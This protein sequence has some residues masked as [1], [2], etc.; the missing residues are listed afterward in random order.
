[1]KKT[2]FVAQMI[3]CKRSIAY[4]QDM[5][6]EA[7]K[8]YTRKR[9]EKGRKQAQEEIDKCKNLVKNYQE[10]LDTCEKEKQEAIA[11]TTNKKV[12]IYCA[13]NCVNMSGWQDRDTVYIPAETIENAQETAKDIMKKQG[14]Y[15]ANVRVEIHDDNVVEEHAR[16][17]NEIAKLQE[18]LKELEKRM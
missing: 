14:G 8:A 11:F 3:D 6:Q 1:M 4:W 17:E 13:Y 12:F 7:E 2:I 16:I 9:S 5:A 10:K 15:V 18:K